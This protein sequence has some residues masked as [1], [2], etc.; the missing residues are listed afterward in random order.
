MVFNFTLGTTSSVALATFLQS[1]SHPSLVSKAALRRLVLRNTLKKHRRTPVSAQAGSLSSVLVA[2]EDYLPYLYALD[3]GLGDW[4]IGDEEVD[5]VLEK[6]VEVEWRP[7][8]RASALGKDAKRVRGAGL[9]YEICFVLCNLGYVNALLAREQ[10]RQLYAQSIFDPDRR[11][12]A[13]TQAT[14]YLTQAVS[15]HES[16]AAQAM[17]IA[18]PAAAV[19]ILPSTQ[20]AL[21]K[22]CLAEA[23]LLAVLKDDPYPAVLMQSQ[24]MEDREWMYKAPTIAKVRAHLFARLSLRAAEHAGAAYAILS[25]S[26]KGRQGAIDGELPKY[27][28]NLERVSKAKACR[29]LGIDADLDGKTGPGIGWLRAGKRSLGIRFD[30]SDGARKKGLSKFKS[31]WKQRREEKKVQKGGEWGADAGAYEESLVLDM[32]DEK[33]TRANDMARDWILAHPSSANCC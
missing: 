18:V 22:A 31:D 29:F 6:E 33:W 27:L 9:D 12:A 4:T 30:E 21:A 17:E 3:A 16:A 2:F 8:L 11:L 7:S 32:L 20:D 25:G 23:T 28:Q 5:V 14:K 15:V 26:G 19:D 10:L 24:D 1:E 13:I